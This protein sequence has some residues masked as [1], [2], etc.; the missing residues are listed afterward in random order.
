MRV[1]FFSLRRQERVEIGVRSRQF[2]QIAF[3]LIERAHFRE[4]GFLARGRIVRTELRPFPALLLQITRREIENFAGAVG[5]LA[6][7]RFGQQDDGCARLAAPRKVV[8][9]FF[10][11]EN[12][13]FRGIFVAG[14]TKDDHRAIGA[15][16]QSRPAFLIL[17]VGLA[18]PRVRC[19]YAHNQH[20]HRCRQRRCCNYPPLHPASLASLGAP[21]RYVR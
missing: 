11:K 10:L 20:P 14:I 6:I 12:G 15:C 8:K 18:K 5:G 21:M 17:A 4:T 19:R 2:L 3:H 16:G 9:T 1:A 13:D 7:R